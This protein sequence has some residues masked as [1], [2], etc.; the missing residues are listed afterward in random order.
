MPKAGRFDYPL[1]DIENAVGRLKKLFDNT[2]KTTNRRDIAIQAMGMKPGGRAQGVVAA[3]DKYRLAETGG[4]EIRIT[5]LGEKILFAATEEEKR[6]RM[7]EAVSNVELFAELTTTYGT[8]PTDQQIR[9]FLQQTAAVDL[10]KI[11]AITADVS[12][13]LKRNQAYLTSA[14]VEGEHEK[15]PMGERQPWD[16]RPLS[17]SVGGDWMQ[18]STT[19][20]IQIT[21]TEGKPFA[22]P[23][24][25][26]K[27]ARSLVNA[28]FD[29]IE[30]KSVHSTDKKQEKE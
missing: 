21:P 16:A 13:K 19:G 23:L 1:L 26:I 14:K 22:F 25:N 15:E 9:L 24:D 20:M 28:V 3:L 30:K 5:P 11:A 2:Q 6:Q 8:T 10:P 4:H 29:E 12:Q 18:T 27:L 17:A 7:K